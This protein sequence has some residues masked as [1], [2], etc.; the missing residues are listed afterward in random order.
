MVN[1]PEWVMRALYADGYVINTEV[2]I[3]SNT[4]DP[5]NKNRY[6][7]VYSFDNSTIQSDSWSMQEALNSESTIQLG[8]LYTK[9]L[10]ISCLYPG[11]S[12]KS[13][14][15]KV[16]QTISNPEEETQTYSIY[17]I[18][19]YISEEAID[20]NDF[21]VSYTIVDL[22]TYAVNQDMKPSVLNPPL[23]LNS[24]VNLW[25]TL[26]SDEHIYSNVSSAP[27]KYW[28]FLDDQFPNAF[29][30]IDSAKLL[31]GIPAI[32]KLSEFLKSF[33]ETVGCNFRISKRTS[34]N[35]FP[36]EYI[37]PR[38]ESFIECVKPFFKFPGTS[39][40][41]YPSKTTYPY[42]AQ[43]SVEMAF[44]KAVPM[45]D[46]PWYIES[47]ASV[48]H[49]VGYSLFRI[50]EGDQIMFSAGTSYQGQAYDIKD[51]PI[52]NAISSTDYTKA[53]SNIN[54]TLTW[55]SHSCA[56]TLEFLIPINAEA[57]DLVRYTL[58]NG[59][60]ITLPI[61]SIST[62]GTHTHIASA[63]CTLESPKGGRL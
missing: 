42:D 36:D 12:Y 8:T 7:R 17:P 32:W 19:G 13:Q 25:L 41:L 22:L 23:T 52:I 62:K 28:S 45:F 24:P 26:M 56:G 20:K 59:T 37:N 30:S 35:N 55:T 50:F 47:K 46:I 4:P 15:V 58:K 39:N 44:P 2:F 6:P 27:G 48:E 3:Y 38:A 29:V 54:D 60:E 49:F 51:N 14:F 31:S 11:Q 5:A 10:S 1:A 63:T 16:K 43:T 18:T 53:A 61:T 40:L 9:T 33:G 57:G 34:D 21:I